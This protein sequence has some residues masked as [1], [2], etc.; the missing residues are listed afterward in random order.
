MSATSGRVT[1]PVLI[2]RADE[3]S[4]LA[5]AVARPPALLLVE[6]EAGVGKTRVVREL[7]RTVELERHRHLIGQCYPLREPF[8][9][10]PVLEALRRRAA[11]PP[12]ELSPVCGALRALLPELSDDLPPAPPPLDDPRA[13][14]HRVFR[15]AAELVGAHAPAVLVLEDLHWADETTLEFLTFLLAQ[16]PA[17]LSVIVTYRRED[18]LPDSLL[19]GLVSRAPADTLPVRVTL[20][21]LSAPD[22]GLLVAAILDTT[23]VSAE[24]ARYLHERTGGMP[25]AVEEYLRLLQ[26][27]GGIV[28]RGGRWARQAL[29]RLE[30]PRALRE[31]IRE[32]R[33]RLDPVAR[34]VVDVVAVFGRAVSDEVIA[35]AT[36]HD[37]GATRDGL[38]AALASGLLQET[39]DDRC[40]FRHALARDAVY[41]EL[42]GPQRRTLHLAAA[43]ALLL[44]PDPPVAQLAHHFEQAGDTAQATRYAEAAA[45]MAAAAHDDTAVCAFLLQALGAP[46]VD[47]TTQFRLACKL[48][49]AA[50]HSFDHS[51]AAVALRRVIDNVE[52]PASDRGELRRL[53]GIQLV[54]TGNASAG[55]AELKQAVVE[56]ADRPQAAMRVMVSLA[57]PWVA[58]GDAAE[59]LQWLTRAES[60]DRAGWDRVDE[61]AFLIDRAT[62]LVSL[63]H[64]SWREAEQAVPLTVDDDAQRR[65]LQRGCVNIAQAQLYIGALRHAQQRLEQSSELVAQAP[66]T[67][68]GGLQ[69]TTQV[70]HD[71]HLGEWDGLEA[72]ARGLSEEMAALPHARIDVE[73]TVGLLELARGEAAA[74]TTLAPLMPT[75]LQAG[76][77]PVFAMISGGLGAWHLA[78]G[79]AEQA[80]AAA[81]QA[82]DVLGTKG[83]WGWLGDV[84]PTA[85]T[86][87]AASGQPQQARDLR[88]Q[89]SDAAQR[90]DAPVLQVACISADAHLAEAAQ[91][92]NPAAAQHAEAAAGFRQLPREFEAL[93]SEAAALRC[94]L[95]GGDVTGVAD[96]SA[97]LLEQLDALPASVEFSRLTK[98]LRQHGI[99]L[100]YRWRGGRRGY[101]DALS[102]REAEVVELVAAGRLTRE[103]ADA[104]FLSPRT[105]EFHVAKAMRKLGVHSRRELGAALAAKNP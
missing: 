7:L 83:L 60:V 101:G 70:L 33:D 42:R 43:R 4:M 36:G 17:D 73:A 56:L 90:L 84:V 15:A 89:V 53:L 98:L 62:A 81:A 92:W 28:R 22:V 48:G 31:S 2:G 61:I 57:A 29:E 11:L 26:E 85:V 86:A 64:P 88:D 19:L 79:R 100:P 54:Q 49:M 32:R 94:R 74:A 67:V 9:L 87:L 58:E 24:F 38:A 14:R 37:I 99:A 18:L 16:R 40:G 104:L 34:D 72:R 47:A 25:F 27:R 21:P 93:R 52:L 8:P 6:G 68:L 30:V 97:T 91:Q 75:A 102:P 51:D 65:E 35:A 59:H 12:R 41:A 55:V 66:S 71:W 103:I 50:S 23:E 20:P 105:V 44:V 46:G 13:E 80:V 3:L 1:S 69:R 77:L 5:R 10:G 82:I 76:S 39:E 96:V 45:D 63:A 95:L 78:S